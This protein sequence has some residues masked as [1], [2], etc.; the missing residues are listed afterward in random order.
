MLH[1]RSGL[2]NASVIVMFVSVVLPVLR[3]RSVKFT[4]SPA[5]VNGPSASLV[6]SYAAL[7]GTAVAVFVSVTVGAPGAAACAVFTIV[8]VSTS[9]C[10]AV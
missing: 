9:A 10:V 4:T 1:A 7:R 6:N 2:K 3:T 8:P 5:A